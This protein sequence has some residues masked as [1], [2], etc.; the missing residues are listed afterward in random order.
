L[1]TCTPNLDHNPI[2]VANHIFKNSTVH[3]GSCF[4]A[5]DSSLATN[6]IVKIVSGNLRQDHIYIT[7]S[8]IWLG[9]SHFLPDII[10]VGELLNLVIEKGYL[11]FM[12]LLLRLLITNY[13]VSQ[14]VISNLCLSVCAWLLSKPDLGSLRQSLI[15]QT[16][17]AFNHWNMAIEC[18]MNIENKLSSLTKIWTHNNQI[19][20]AK[21][22]K[23][24]VG[25]KLILA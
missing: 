10:F 8:I 24:N 16:Y 7:S 9:C 19:N 4:G 3:H 17:F 18:T 11:G 22:Q 5:N 23:H 14:Q 15:L 6:L 20:E 13:F 1:P 25:I 21:I 2:I 12:I